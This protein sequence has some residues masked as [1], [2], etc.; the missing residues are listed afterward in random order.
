MS[1]SHTP[2]EM[3]GKNS[4]ALLAQ[5]DQ[6]IARAVHSDT[7]IFAARAEGAIVEDVDG[8]RYIDFAVGHGAVNIGHARPEITR[9]ITEQ[10]AKFTHTSFTA[11][12]Y[13]PYITLAQR[14]ATLTP[15]T[16]PKKA[17]LFTTGAEAVENAVK[18]ARYATGRPAII[19]FDQA[20]HGRTLLA[21]TMTAR[22]KPYKDG[23]GPYA[24]E[25][26]RAPFPYPYHMAGTPEEITRHCIDELKRLFIGGIAPEKVAA[27]V[28]EPVQGEGGMIVPTPGFLPALKALCEEHGILF[29]A[30][31]IQSGFCR[32]GRMFAIEH[33]GVVPDLMVLAKSLGAGMPISA[34]VGRAEVMDALPPGSLGGT[35][36]GNPVSCVAALAV[37]DLFE[38][39]DMAARSFETGALIIEHLTQ[40]QKHFPFIGEVRGLGGMIGMEFVKDAETHEPDPEIVDRVLAAAYH[41][42]LVLVKAGIYDNVIR[43]LAPLSTTPEQLEEAMNILE[44]AIR[45]VATEEGT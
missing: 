38:Q 12:M 42:G 23:F 6:W 4:E 5:R 43:I 9:A 28:V 7:E 11:I 24:P 27:V 41:R 18:I 32:T 25:V 40:L 21:M 29:I 33:E 19:V 31:E 3:I 37:L 30:D 16:F 45:S 39:E 15:G 35:Y 34:V 2:G 1:S 22:V 13:E 17:A 44:D 36:S 14:L 26:Y 10:A 20:F 8:R